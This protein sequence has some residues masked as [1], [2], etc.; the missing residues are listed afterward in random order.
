MGAINSDLKR[1]L[2]RLS[3]ENASLL[4]NQLNSAEKDMKDRASLGYT[5]CSFRFCKR[6]FSPSFPGAFE[7]HFRSQGLEVFVTNYETETRIVVSW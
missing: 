3:C 2:V 6:K 4:R 7:E 5:D 1:E